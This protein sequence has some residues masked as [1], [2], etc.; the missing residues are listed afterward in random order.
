MRGRGEDNKQTLEQRNDGMTNSLTSVTKDNLIAGTGIRR[1]T[2]LEAERLQGFE[3]GWT[4]G[5]SDSQRYRCLGN[6]VSV[7]VVQAV[8]ER[9]LRNP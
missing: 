4:A 2:P 3:D 9:L 5:I 7:P 8:M 6:A 1:L